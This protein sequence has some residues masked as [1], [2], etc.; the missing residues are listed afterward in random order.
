VAGTASVTD[1]AC[2][3]SQS[4]TDAACVTSQ[5]VTDTCDFTECELLHGV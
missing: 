4:V 3:T 2:V 1:A 5:S